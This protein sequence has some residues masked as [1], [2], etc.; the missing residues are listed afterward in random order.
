MDVFKLT[1]PNKATV[2][3]DRWRAEPE[4]LMILNLP[5]P[6]PSLSLRL[7]LLVA[8]LLAPSRRQRAGKADLLPGDGAH[9]TSALRALLDIISIVCLF[10]HD[11]ERPKRN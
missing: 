5:L 4:S 10:Y 6:S 7:K 3:C 2:P 9:M 1:L 8:V 11:W